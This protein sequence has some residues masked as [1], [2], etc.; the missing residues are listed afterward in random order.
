MERSTILKI[1]KN[2]KKKK[3]K[4]YKYDNIVLVKKADWVG[5]RKISFDQKLIFKK[6][7][8]KKRQKHYDSYYQT[9][10][11]YPLNEKK[12]QSSELKKIDLI[13]PVN[14]PIKQRIIYHLKFISMNYPNSIKDIIKIIEKY[15]STNPE[16]LSQI[17]FKEDFESTSSKGTNRLLRAWLATGRVFPL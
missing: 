11:R 1:S 3:A 14:I 9:H 10:K 4:A 5:K 13:L 8:I 6:E 2:Y 16:E 15:R 12:G 7:A 17:I